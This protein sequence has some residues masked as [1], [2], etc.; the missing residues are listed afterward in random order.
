MNISYFSHYF[1]PEI[2]APSARIYDLARQWLTLGHQVQ[3]VTCFPNHPTGQIYP[4]YRAGFYMQ[5]MLDNIQVHR[6]WTYITPNKGFV[7]KTLG[8]I[9]FLPAALLWSNQRMQ[10]SDVVVGTSPTF[11]AA[12]AAAASGMQR[13]CPFVMEV[14]DLWPAIFVELGILRNQHLIHSLEWL[15]LALYRYATR[16]VTVT[17]AFRR[18]LIERGV[19]AEK[20]VTIPNGAD[21]DFWQPMPA[22]ADLREQ[23]GLQG[24]FV[25]LYIGAHGISHALGRILETAR[26]LKDYT[27]IQ[28]L[29]VGEGAEKDQLI[30]QAQ[31]AGLNNVRFL[32]PVSRPDVRRYYALAD[33]CLVPLRNIPLFET[34]IPS[35]MF[36][37][38]AMGRPIVAS[39]RGEAADILSRSKGALVVEPEDSCAIAQALLQ[40]YQQKAQAEVLGQQG[41]QFVVNNYSRQLLAS[42]YLD[43]LQA[44]ID[45]YQQYQQYQPRRVKR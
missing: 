22:P 35:K 39:V 9:S 28:F 25:V 17:E 13:R 12:M 23:L 31:Q 27:D 16:I 10:P 18:N 20:V 34:F 24:R 43:V 26:R 11:F 33:V 40:L 5:E 44:A 42:K 21:V 14:R 19:P 45:Q 30:Q 37:I 2:G 15:E 4:G 7:K 29:F 38:M 6:H 41:R 32:D 3:V 1:A 36:E 8:H